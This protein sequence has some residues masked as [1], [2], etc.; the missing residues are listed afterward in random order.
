MVALSETLS[1]ELDPFGILVSAVCPGFVRTP[2][3]SS[4]SGS[5]V[6]ANK[7]AARLI[8]KSP[9][10]ANQV[11]RAVMTGI[12][13]KRMVI[14]PDRTARIAVLTKRTMR[15]LYD[16]QQRGFAARIFAMT[17]EKA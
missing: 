17:E 7:I 16:R 9:Y 11:A 13:R 5:D 8:E 1:Y 6:A 10:T 4:I 2:L 14:V 12:D 15:P 3:A